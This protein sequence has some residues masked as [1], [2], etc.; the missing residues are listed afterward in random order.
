MAK[1]L[2]HAY[3]KRLWYVEQYLIPSMLKQGI[4]KNDIRVYNDIN[5]DGNLRACLNAFASCTEDGGTWHLQ[6]DVLI[7][8]NFKKR[9]EQNDSGLVCGFSSLLYDGDIEEKKGTVKREDMWFSFPCI[10]I[11]NQWARECAEWVSSDIIGNPVYKKFWESGRNDDWAFRMYL[12]TFHK[13][14]VALNIMP[15]LVDHIDFLLGGGSGGKRKH[16]VRSQYFEDADLVEEL[17][18]GMDNNERRTTS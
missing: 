11:P 6:D 3:P 18:H 4:D 9:T 12:S 10:R 8:R 15:N 14:C 13:D 5:A 16:E 17:S 1:Y 2:I 7:C